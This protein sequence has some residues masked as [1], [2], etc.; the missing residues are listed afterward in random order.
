M[1]TARYSK[2]T[3]KATTSLADLAQLKYEDNYS[4]KYERYS[5]MDESSL[6]DLWYR[7]WVA[8]K[9]NAWTINAL[10][11]VMTDKNIVLPDKE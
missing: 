6:L 3:H 9:W 7:D 1:E 2:T 10:G 11:D 5:K 4:K 8:E